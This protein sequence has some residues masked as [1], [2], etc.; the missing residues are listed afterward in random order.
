[1]E[2]K[3]RRVLRLAESGILLAFSMVLSLITL[4]S[5]PYGGSITAASMLPL[6][7]LAY[8]HGTAWGLLCGTVY[9]LMQMLL[10]LNNLSYAT[11]IWA[12]AAIILLDYLIAFAAIGLSG[13][14]RKLFHRQ[15]PGLLIGAFLGCFVRYVCHVISGCTVWA[16]LSI[17]TTDAAW[18]SITYN[19]GYMLPETVITLI[20][21]AYVS[22]VLE[23]RGE[24]VTR[25]AQYQKQSMGVSVWRAI[26]YAVPTVAIVVASVVAFD[27]MAL[28]TGFDVTALAHADWPL[29]LGILGGGAVLTAACLLISCVWKKRV[30]DR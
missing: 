2:Q 29:I 7:L 9:G 1:M 26:T 6:M 12:G 28:E 5:F 21:A 11:S 23:F 30:R 20:V 16:G 24:Q 14:F 15:T 17:P 22:N 13:C 19:I 8:R 25:P 3:K 10:G 18:Y 4:L 27:A